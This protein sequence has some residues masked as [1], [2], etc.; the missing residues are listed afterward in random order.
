MSQQFS[1]VRVPKAAEL[2]ASTLRMQIVTGQLTED[3]SLPSEALLIE[4]FAV[5]RPTLREA[6]RILESESLID[7]R[8]G[9]RGGARVKVPDGTVAARQLG[10]MLQYR[11][12]AMDD[13]YRA[14]TA[15]ETTLGALLAR[16]VDDDVLEQLEQAI[17]EGKTLLDNEDEWAKADIDFHLLVGRLTGNQTLFTLLEMM[18]TIILEARRRYDDASDPVDLKRQHHE[19]H[20]THEYFVA[21]LRRGTRDEAADMWRQHLAAIEKHYTAR[22]LAETVVEMM[23]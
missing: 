11:A 10:Y 22:P 12:T 9:A 19:V 5:S 16:N 20:R 15:L 6:F 1:S 7:V 13:V 18:S 21:L 17:A 2:V 3:S 14:R 23:T 8:R 4:Q